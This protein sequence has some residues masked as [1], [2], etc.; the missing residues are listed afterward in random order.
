[1]DINNLPSKK[2]TDIIIIILLLG[3]IVLGYITY[4]AYTDNIYYIK[5]K[6][7]DICKDTGAF[8]IE[9]N[10]TQINNFKIEYPY[11]IT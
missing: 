3:L 4:K 8:V 11:N 1:M 2:T 5:T 10:L 6:P 7:C 9:K